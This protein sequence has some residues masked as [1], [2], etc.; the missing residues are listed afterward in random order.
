MSSSGPDPTEAVWIATER[1]GITMHDPLGEASTKTRCSRNTLWRGVWMLARVAVD[2]FAALPC[3]R[4]W[5]P[6]AGDGGR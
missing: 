4:C 1:R 2:E 3:R 5:P 6:N